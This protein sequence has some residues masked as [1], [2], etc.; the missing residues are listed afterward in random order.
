M[1][2]HFPEKIKKILKKDYLELKKLKDHKKMGEIF[3]IVQESNESSMK[4]AG[5]IIKRN[6]STEKGVL[7]IPCGTMEEA[8]ANRGENN[9]NKNIS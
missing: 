7:N 9:E 8:R 4:R 5:Q 1:Y 3:K 2:K 6:L